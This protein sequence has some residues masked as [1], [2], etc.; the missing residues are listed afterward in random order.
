VLTIL[1]IL[2]R[3]GYVTHEKD[4]RAFRF[5]P[6]VDRRSARKN[7]LADVLSRFFDNSPELLV[8]DLLGGEYADADELERLRRTVELA[9][10]D[11][12][13]GKLKA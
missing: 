1:G 3:K 10:G 11:D 9:T 8:L 4:G 5:A 13:D 6:L 2:E 7:A 12:P